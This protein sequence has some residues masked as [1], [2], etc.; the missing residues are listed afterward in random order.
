[1]SN[2]SKTRRAWLIPAAVGTVL[3]IVALTAVGL[4]ALA[5]TAPTGPLAKVVL[6]DEE[7]AKAA[8]REYLKKNL[9]SGEW[10]EVEWGKL[11]PPVNVQLR[12][13]IRKP[14]TGSYIQLRYRTH[15]QF[16][17]LQ[18]EDDTFHVDNGHVTRSHYSYNVKRADP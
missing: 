11:V 7:Q 10:E 17:V 5:R 9:D 2:V 3:L 18:L 14:E 8:V 4:Q 6:S 12:G 13:D 1:M 16:G 15:N